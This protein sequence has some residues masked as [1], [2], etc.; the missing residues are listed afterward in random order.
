M[1]LPQINITQRLIISN[2]LSLLIVSF[3]V[4]MVIRSLYYVESTLKN[5]TSTHVSDLIVNSEI[6]RRV[7]TLTSR[8]KLLEQTFLF[9]ETTLSEEAFNVDFQLQRLRDLSTNEG[10]SQKIDAFIDNFHRFLGSS[11]ALN[12]ILKQTN[13]IDATL[14][15]Q[16]DQLEFAIADSKLRHLD[17]P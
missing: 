6:S 17:Q 16:L 2:L 8:V 5:E 7:F 14:A 4:I 13:Q 15:E 10:F 1:K 9:S 12:R 11:L 3:A